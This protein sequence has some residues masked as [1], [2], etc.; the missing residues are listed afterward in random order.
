MKHLKVA[1]L[2][3]ILLLALSLSGCSY[4]QVDMPQASMG[5]LDL[6]AW[7][8][9]TGQNIALNGDWSFY[10]NQLISPGGFSNKGTLTGFYPVPGFWTG[11]EDLNLPSE[12]QATYRLIIEG[13]S[14]E[15]LLSIRLPQIYTEYILWING[16]R[17]AGNGPLNGDNFT[18]MSTDILDFYTESQTIEIVLQ[19]R[20]S[21]HVLG[22]ISQSLTLG[23][24]SLIRRDQSIG[25]TI[26]LLLGFVCFGAGIYHLLA[27]L[28]LTK[29]REL[30]F[31]GLLCI[32]AS[33]HGLMFNETL[34]VQLFPGLPY[35][36]GAAIA[37]STVP[38]IVIAALL[39][40]F[41]LYKDDIPGLIGET[42][43]AI[44]VIYVIT[45]ILLPPFVYTSL[46]MPYAVCAGLASIFGLFVAF[47]VV[48][49]K[50]PNAWFY[51]IGMIF[52]ILAA[53][54]DLLNFFQLLNTT[55]I[56]SGGVTV[57]I[58]S[59]IVMLANHNAITY[60]AA[61]KLAGDLQVRENQ[62]IKTET[63]YLG[64][65]IKP[66]FLYNALNTIA[67]C[68]RTDAAAAENLIL[69][70]SRYLRGTLDFE[71]LGDMVTL[72]KELELVK[73]YTSIELARFDNFEVFYQIDPGLLE[74]KLPPLSIQP[75]VENAIKHGVR[76]MQSGGRID[77]VIRKMNDVVR[78]CVSDNGS[79][80]PDGEIPQLMRPQAAQSIGLYN[81]NT[82]LERLWGQG[83]VIDS[84]AGVGTRVCFEIPVQEAV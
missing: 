58:T 64:V 6:T 51:L 63:A 72:G 57:F 61:E 15:Q 81:V 33:I 66:H 41:V 29:Q 38:L 3:M 26:D 44:S 84:K 53:A 48:I 52:F 77:I 28:Y 5:T 32:L 43:I 46:F 59:Q 79:G 67:D 4:S 20:N 24:T 70:L 12:G 8:P 9:G 39:Y 30:L 54:N 7:V 17:F 60:R 50:R 16:Q 78:I 14:P 55:Y 18:Y 42:L 69:S 13:V 76:R 22:G 82:R 80:I 19:V 65:Q 2:L 34:L 73:A 74:L 56:L 31:F 40:S 47:K 1:A 11:Y 10:W 27:F 62:V 49:R 36:I 83:L 68:C 75:I 71:N 21:S 23:T 25:M 45:V 35:G 37:I